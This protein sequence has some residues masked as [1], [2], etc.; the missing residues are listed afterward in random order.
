MAVSEYQLVV[1]QAEKLSPQEQLR[2]IQQLA[3]RLAKTQ[4]KAQPPHYLQYGK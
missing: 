2:L 4:L 3:E 1:K